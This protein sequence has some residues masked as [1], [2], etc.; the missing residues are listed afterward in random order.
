MSA[1]EI[2][3]WK[4]FEVKKRRRKRKRGKV[5]DVVWDVFLVT[6]S[7]HVQKWRRREY[8]EEETLVTSDTDSFGVSVTV[9]QLIKTLTT[10][11]S[12]I[13][14]E[15][16]RQTYKYGCEK[17]HQNSDCT[18]PC[19]LNKS[20][21]NINVTSSLSPFNCRCM[22]CGTSLHLLISSFQLHS[23]DGMSFSFQRNK[24]VRFPL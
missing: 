17:E 24:K 21:N 13:I 12:R 11:R 18:T 1:L 3:S 10:I 5:W 8:G 9:K 4:E 6:N 14:D 2:R 20:C 16:T 22:E 19:K 23:V 7:L 15:Y